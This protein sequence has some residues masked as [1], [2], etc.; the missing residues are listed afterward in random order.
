MERDTKILKIARIKKDYTIEQI[1]E[2]LRINKSTYIKY[3]KGNYKNMKLET[4]KK[5]MDLLEINPME[6][7]ENME[8]LEDEE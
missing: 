1:S 4:V 5:L 2:K 8:P 6:L 7:I 3:E